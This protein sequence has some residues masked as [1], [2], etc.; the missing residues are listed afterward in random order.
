[1]IMG[2]VFLSASAFMVSAEEP[3]SDEPLILAFFEKPP[4]LRGFSSGTI[5]QGSVNSPT[6]DN[7]LS[8][9]DSEQGQIERANFNNILIQMGA[10][11]SRPDYSRDFGCLVEALYFE[12][13]G[14]SL[15]G[16]RAVAEVI[17]NRVRSVDFPN[18]ICGVVHQGGIKKAR[19]Q[20]S[21]YCDGKPEVFYEKNA[22]EQIRNMLLK[23]VSGHYPEIF[24]ESTHFHASHVKPF[25]VS[26]FEFLGRAGKHYFYSH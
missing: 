22:Y 4:L 16:Q 20:F 24:N 21:Y 10:P 3:T 15:E 13:R 6:R 5:D 18:T 1:M 7:H 2:S 8:F 17:I 26:D 9:I 25:W 19:C 14:E 11:K 23:F 12:A